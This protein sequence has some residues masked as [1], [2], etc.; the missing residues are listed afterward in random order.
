MLAAALSGCNSGGSQSADGVGS[1]DMT[2]TLAT[3]PA[4]SACADPLY[5]GAGYYSP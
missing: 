3:S 2:V 5:Q 4:G 1:V